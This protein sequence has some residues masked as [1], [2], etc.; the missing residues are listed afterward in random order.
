MTV[1]CG[2]VL[3]V[4][5]QQEPVAVA[6]LYNVR[7][8]Q[9]EPSSQRNGRITQHYGASLTKIFDLYPVI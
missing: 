6:T 4:V 9:H 5:Y 2:Q 3:C 7:A 8:V 1:S